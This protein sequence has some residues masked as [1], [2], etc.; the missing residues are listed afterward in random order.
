MTEETAPESK[1]GM[2]TRRVRI[3]GMHEVITRQQHDADRRP[4]GVPSVTCRLYG[5]DPELPLT[6]SALR[7]TIAC[8]CA[9]AVA[10]FVA[11]PHHLPFAV[12]AR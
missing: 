10:K 7:D 4:V 11:E 9:D 5:R 2:V 1:R 12:P 3:I 6:G 8:G